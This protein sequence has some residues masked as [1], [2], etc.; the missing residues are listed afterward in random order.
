M[1]VFLYLLRSSARPTDVNDTTKKGVQGELLDQ[2]VR[3]DM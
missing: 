2:P 1:T 3:P